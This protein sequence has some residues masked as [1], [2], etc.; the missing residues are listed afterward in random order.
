MPLENQ[1]EYLKTG[2]LFGYEGTSGGISS[3]F[4]DSH[5][6]RV[7]FSYLVQSSSILDSSLA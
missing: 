5:P 6:A 7:N 2:L 4:R 1:E 3:D